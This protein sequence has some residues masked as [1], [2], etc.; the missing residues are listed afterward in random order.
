MRG[1]PR[2]FESKRNIAAAVHQHVADDI[3]AGWDNHMEFA[4]ENPNFYKLMWSPRVAANS[5]AFRDAYQILYERMEF[6]ASRGQ[7]RVSPDRA[8]QMIKAATRGA[9]LSAISQP[10]MYGDVSFA[11]QL[12]EAESV[13]SP[14]PLTPNKQ[15]PGSR[16]QWTHSCHRS[17]H[18]QEQGGYRRYAAHSTRAGAV[19]AVAHSAGGYARS[20]TLDSEAGITG[21][22]E[23]AI[24]RL[25]PLRRPLV[26]VSWR[27]DQHASWGTGPMNVPS[28]SREAALRR[29]TVALPK[30]SRCGCGQHCSAGQ[31][32]QIWEI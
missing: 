3:R 20:G 30:A 29:K 21:W 16:R 23:G 32:Q 25:L 19:V 24:A 4:R 14:W 18:P 11:T 6:G 10:G 27:K 12:G 26:L 22:Q 8:M 28:S 31:G 7:L 15:A 1:P 9:A 5:T 2:A 17:R 13:R